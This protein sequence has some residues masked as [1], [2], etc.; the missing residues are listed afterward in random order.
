MTQ[1]GRTEPYAA[2]TLPP[3]TDLKDLKTFTDLLN[4]LLLDK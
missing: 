1:D 3:K 2:T 4:K